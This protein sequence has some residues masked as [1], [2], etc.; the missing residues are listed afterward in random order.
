MPTEFELFF[1]HLRTSPSLLS[2]NQPFYIHTMRLPTPV[3]ATILF[4]L[5]TLVSGCGDHEG[6]CTTPQ[7]CLAAPQGSISYGKSQVLS[8]SSSSPSRSSFG[9]TS[10]PLRYHNFFHPPDL[11]L[12]NVLIP[13]LAHMV[14]HRSL[15]RRNRQSLLYVSARTVRY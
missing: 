11:D 14:G 9:Q 7:N 2:P 1:K 8:A 3:V 15:P 10:E 5:S 13:A 6:F 12:C 4:S